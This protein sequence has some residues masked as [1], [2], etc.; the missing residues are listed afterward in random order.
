MSILRTCSTTR[1]PAKDFVKSMKG[2]NF[3]STM[4]SSKAV[5]LSGISTISGAGGGGGG[6][7][8]VGVGGRLMLEFL[9]GW[10]SSRLN[11]VPLVCATAKSSR[12]DVVASSLVQDCVQRSIHE[13]TSRLL[14][15]L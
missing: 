3:P 1:G 10:K 6:G 13:V 14:T 4:T 15:A 11:N 9:S 5:T 12:R 2:F 7:M 8:T